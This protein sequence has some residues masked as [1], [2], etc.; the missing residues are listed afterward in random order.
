MRDRPVGWQRTGHVAGV[1]GALRSAR[2][3]PRGSRRRPWA[4]A[5]ADLAELG[6]GRSERTVRR[7][8][9]QGKLD[10]RSLESV[11]L[12]WARRRERAKARKS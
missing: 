3:D 1:R 6:V 9:S 2:R 5:Y 10:P 4:S 11:C 12:T 7:L 8:V